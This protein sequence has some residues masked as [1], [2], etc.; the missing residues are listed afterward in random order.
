MYAFHYRLRQRKEL[1]MKK[2]NICIQ[3]LICLC[4]KCK[5]EDKKQHLKAYRKGVPIKIHNS[6]GLLFLLLCFPLPNREGKGVN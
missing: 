1:K 3:L 5:A 4:L 2:M 6:C